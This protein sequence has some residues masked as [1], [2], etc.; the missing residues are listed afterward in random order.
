MRV[1]GTQ[2]LPASLSLDAVRGLSSNRE[3]VAFLS[4]ALSNVEETLHAGAAAV[5]LRVGSGLGSSELLAMGKGWSTTTSRNQPANFDSPSPPKVRVASIADSAGG[6][7]GPESMA[8]DAWSLI[9][10]VLF[11]HDELQATLEVLELPGDIQSDRRL[12]A[13]IWAREIA[14]LIVT[15]AG[16][17]Q[18]RSVQEANRRMIEDLVHQLSNP[19]NASVLAVRELSADVASLVE[20]RRLSSIDF[21]F[22][23]AIRLLE[24]A[25]RVVRAQRVYQALSESPS[26]LQ[27]LPVRLSGAVLAQIVRQAA[28]ESKILTE[29]MRRLNYRTRLDAL[30]VN[31]VVDF[32]LDHL[33]QC[34]GQVFDNVR[35]YAYAN[36]AVLVDAIRDS[37]T[38]SIRIRSTGCPVDPAE[39]GYVVER[40]WRGESARFATSEGQGLGLWIVDQLARANGARLQVQPRGDETAVV[41][42]IPRSK[43]D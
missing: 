26:T 8:S 28:E 20:A 35:K 43:A 1:A 16:S 9:T 12:L 5:R 7:S 14:D 29:P 19:L 13:E 18:A 21:K 41:L 2:A 40:G 6:P 23:R 39:A 37:R 17:D 3:F 24:K 25:S 32:D 4:G 33:D 31:D 15:A 36:S 34:L 11:E 38:L 27:G 30:H 22:R 42:T 10:I